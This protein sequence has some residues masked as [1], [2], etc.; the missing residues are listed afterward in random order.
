M[1]LACGML[2][3]SRMQSA[4]ADIGPRFVH[5]V[6]ALSFSLVVAYLYA[7]LERRSVATAGL[8]DRSTFVA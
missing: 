2:A 7:R 1:R 5:R 4:Q 8:R 3:R 6:G